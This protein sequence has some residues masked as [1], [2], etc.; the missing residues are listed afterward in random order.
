MDATLSVPCMHGLA[1]GAR[2]AIIF[3]YT[4]IGKAY[5]PPLLT[6]SKLTTLTILNLK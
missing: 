4:P 3:S 5:L 6:R 2:Q 1:C